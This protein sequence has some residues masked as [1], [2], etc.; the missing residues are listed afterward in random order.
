MTIDS[1]GDDDDDEIDASRD[2][3]EIDTEGIIDLSDDEVGPIFMWRDDEDHYVEVNGS[4]LLLEHRMCGAKGCQQMTQLD[5]CTAHLFDMGLCVMS[6]SVDG[7]GFG[8]FAA[9]SFKKGETVAKFVGA[10]GKFYDNAKYM[11]SLCGDN[12]L[13]CATVRCAAACANTLHG[14]NNCTISHSRKYKLLSIQSNVAIH[15]GSEIFVSYG[16]S[17]S[18]KTKA[19]SDAKTKTKTKT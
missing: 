7:A 14:R 16:T 8:L 1:S 5:Y 12:Y 4:P 3:A 19:E 18:L 17:Y 10:P 11:L 6:S 13:D 9:K 2:N 15:S